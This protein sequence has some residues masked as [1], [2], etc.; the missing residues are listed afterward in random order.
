MFLN[1]FS[2]R[3]AMHRWFPCALGMSL[4]LSSLEAQAATLRLGD[5][6]FSEAGGSFNITGG[7]VTRDESPIYVIQ[8]EVYGP[9][10]NLYT[11]ITGLPQMY[12]V[13]GFRVQ[14]RVINLTGT[15]WNFFD[16][17]L[18]ES[19]MVPSPEQ[20]GLS[21]AQGYNSIRPFVSDRLPLVN[22]TTDVRDFVNFSGGVVNPGEVGIFQFAIT[23]N[24]PINQFYLLQR[25]NYQPAGVGFVQPPPPPQPPAPPA[26]PAPTPP[27]AAPTPPVAVP[28]PTPTPTPPAPAPTNQP[29]PLPEPPILVPPDNSSTPDR[30]AAVPEP[31]T[32]AGL[33]L[34][35]A[36]GWWARRRS[37]H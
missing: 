12:P 21:F 4:L 5:L 19:P 7:F 35:A 2:V 34:A 26:P 28:E 14:Y 33:A 6:S 15:P 37:Q 3:P 10:I 31:T 18:R 11:R 22:E 8:Q 27:V 29:T 17:E 36:G 32:V 13:I 16:N 25:P 23:D 1:Q 9:D 24:S 20:D 30:S